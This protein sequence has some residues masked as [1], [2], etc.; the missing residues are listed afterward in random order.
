MDPLFDIQLYILRYDNAVLNK[1]LYVGN[2]RVLGRPLDI[3]STMLHFII[4]V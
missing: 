1:T 2:K 4:K 3:L